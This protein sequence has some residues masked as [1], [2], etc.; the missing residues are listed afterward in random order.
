M[1]TR[2]EFQSV[3][4]GLQGGVNVYFQPPDNVNVVY[5]AIFYNRDFQQDFH[6]DDI[7]YAS[8]VR[9]QV[10]VI[11]RDPDSQIPDKVSAL[12]M[13][14]FVRHYTTAGLNHDIYYVYF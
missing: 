12:P 8:T 6:A 13:S 11:D 9:Y 7:R 10:T 4:E 1:G 2:L 5:P 3:L 14:K